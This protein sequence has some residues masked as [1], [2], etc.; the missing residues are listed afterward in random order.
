MHI[1]EVPVYENVVLLETVGTGTLMQKDDVNTIDDKILGIK[2]EAYDTY[3]HKQVWKNILI[4]GIR[5]YQVL[6]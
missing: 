5:S 4:T 1:I 6:L 3:K 2:N